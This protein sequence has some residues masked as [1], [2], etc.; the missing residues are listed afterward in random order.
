MPSGNSSETIDFGSD[1][2]QKNVYKGLIRAIANQTSSGEYLWSKDN[3]LG[4][5]G[6]HYNTSTASYSSHRIAW[7][8]TAYS[9]L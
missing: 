7:G 2:N 4:I 1:T 9:L 3:S 8:F 5:V 6:L